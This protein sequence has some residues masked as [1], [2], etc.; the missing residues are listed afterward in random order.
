LGVAQID[1]IGGE[2]TLHCDVLE[3]GD[4]TGVS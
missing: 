3:E 4:A 2:S 1:L